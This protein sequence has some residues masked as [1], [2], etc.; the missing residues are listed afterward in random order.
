[1]TV[2]SLTNEVNVSLS[3]AYAGFALQPQVI[4]YGNNLQMV[5]GIFWAL[6]DF[7]LP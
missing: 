2:E 7:L 6:T 4:Q 1:M 3:P 5:V